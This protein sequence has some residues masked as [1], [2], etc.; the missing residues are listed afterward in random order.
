MYFRCSVLKYSK[1]KR[2]NFE[3]FYKRFNLQTL[4]ETIL[5]NYF[6]KE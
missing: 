3:K 6:F 5:Y 1:I 2:E 4:N